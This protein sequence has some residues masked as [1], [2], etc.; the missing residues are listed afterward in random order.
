MAKRRDV[1]DPGGSFG[2]FKSF[3]DLWHDK[4]REEKMT[5]VVCCE[6]CLDVVLR[7]CQGRNG[8]DTSVVDQDVDG[9]NID[10]LIEACCGSTNGSLG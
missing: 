9:W 5:D 4:I 8:H 2:G 6:G 3:D 7:E 10:V 1:D